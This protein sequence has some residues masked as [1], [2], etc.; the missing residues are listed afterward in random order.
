MKFKVIAIVILAVCVVAAWRDLTAKPPPIERLLETP[1]SFPA[2]SQAGIR[3]VA[4]PSA[5]LAGLCQRGRINVFAFY[6]DSCPGSRQLRG[7]IGG[8]TK[9]RPDVAFQMVDLGAQWR[10]K[11]YK[12]A[13]G[14]ELGSVP[15]VMIYDSEGTLLAGDDRSSK[16]GLEL[17]SDWINREIE[18]RGPRTST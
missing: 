11:D 17:L 3:Q 10:Q 8:F 14:I 5:N 13:Y 7:Y 15:H 1:E 12:T 18:T 16:G 9:L 6:S 4:L 2:N